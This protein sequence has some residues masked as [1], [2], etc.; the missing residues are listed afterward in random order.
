M[1]PFGILGG[2]DPCR[3]DEKLNVP[4]PGIKFTQSGHEPPQRERRTGTKTNLDRRTRRGYGLGF[5]FDFFE[6]VRDHG[7]KPLT[8][9]GEPL[10]RRIMSSPQ[11][12]PIALQ[13][14]WG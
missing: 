14:G 11:S 1:P 5:L 6:R 2:A 3:R 7:D 9:L 8:F 10:T 12:W 4:V 13:I